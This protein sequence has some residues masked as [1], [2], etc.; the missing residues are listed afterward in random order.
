MRVLEGISWGQE[1]FPEGE[2]TPKDPLATALIS[3]A[4]RSSAKVTAHWGLHQAGGHNRGLNGGPPENTP[5]R[6]S[7]D[8]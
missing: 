2:I 1:E 5:T 4:T 6:S 7:P 3:R 8:L